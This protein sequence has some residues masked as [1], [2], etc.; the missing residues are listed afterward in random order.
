MSLNFIVLVGIQLI[1]NVI[2]GFATYSHIPQKQL[3]I[4]L[5]KRSGLLSENQ[6]THNASYLTFINRTYHLLDSR[7]DET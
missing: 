6:P 1:E 5:P 3:Q 4:Y 2:C 7:S